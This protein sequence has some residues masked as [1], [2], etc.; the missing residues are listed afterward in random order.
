MVFYTLWLFIWDDIYDE[1][2]G[3]CDELVKPAMNSSHRQML[4]YLAFRLGLTEKG[5]SRKRGPS[6]P[7]PIVAIL[8]SPARDM[9]L[10]YHKAGRQRFFDRVKFYLD[11]LVVEQDYLVRKDMPSIETYRSHRLDTSAV[12]TYCAMIEYVIGAAIPQELFAT[13]ELNTLWDETNRLI[14]WYAHLLCPWQTGPS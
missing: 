4:D 13:A 6:A 11:S 7:S 12:Y 1:S 10:G 3:E 2:E 14:S 8:G 9:Q 5:K